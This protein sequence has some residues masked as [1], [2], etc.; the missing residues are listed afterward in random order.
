MQRGPHPRLAEDV[1]RAHG[2]LLAR[3]RPAERLGHHLDLAV[4]AA[5]VAELAKELQ[6]ALE[7]GPALFPFASGE[8]E[9]AQQ[10]EGLGLASAGAELLVD[11]VGPPRQA[12]GLVE[13]SLLVPPQPTA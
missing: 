12:L 5:L 10:A 7:K 4:I 6:G 9:T 11:L 3:A 1:R 8:G 13:V 2:E